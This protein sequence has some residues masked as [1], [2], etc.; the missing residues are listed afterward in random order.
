MSNIDLENKYNKQNISFEQVFRT[1]NEAQLVCFTPPCTFFFNQKINEILKCYYGND[2]DTNSDDTVRCVSHQESAKIEKILTLKV[3]PFMI[4]VF[5]CLKLKCPD[6][7]FCAFRC[8][9]NICAGKNNIF[10]GGVNIFQYRQIL[11]DIVNICYEY[12]YAELSFHVQNELT[13]VNNIICQFYSNGCYSPELVLTYI[14]IR[15][16]SDQGFDSAQIDLIIP[17]I[18]SNIKCINRADLFSYIYWDL[19]IDRLCRC[20]VSNTKLIEL[21]ESIIIRRINETKCVY[22]SKDPVIPKE[23]YTYSYCLETFLIEHLAVNFIFKRLYILNSQA[24]TQ[25]KPYVLSCKPL[26]A[27][28]EKEYNEYTCLERKLLD[29]L[30]KC[31]PCKPCNSC[32]GS[33]N[34][35]ND[36]N[37]IESYDDK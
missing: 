34:D 6:F 25:I 5:N 15:C 29:L 23:I 1:I 32:K 28:S 16:R 31:K 27:L 21:I 17:S 30:K 18:C 3:K 2:S 19:L 8:P 24:M 22:E 13:Y 12:S 26:C 36:V 37:V 35:V 14:D 7:K 9:P 33:A 11:I 20:G 4:E 10:L